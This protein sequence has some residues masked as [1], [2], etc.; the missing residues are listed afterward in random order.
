LVIQQIQTNL[1]RS[2]SPTDSQEGGRG[3]GLAKATD[4]E[5]GQ[6]DACGDSDDSDIDDKEN[7]EKENA[8]N[9]KPLLSRSKV[10]LKATGGR[11]FGSDA[12]TDH[13]CGQAGSHFSTFTPL[14]PIPRT[15]RRRFE[16]ARATDHE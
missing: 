10:Q 16:L 1:P 15:G 6:S 4:H 2:R 11:W 7:H 13:N 8:D 3:F 9:A 12:A 14:Y 5:C